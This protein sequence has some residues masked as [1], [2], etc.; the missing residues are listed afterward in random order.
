M[1]G[2]FGD[3]DEGKKTGTIIYFSVAVFLTILAIWSQVVFV[4]SPYYAC[5]LN[6]RKGNVIEVDD[7]EITQSAV[8]YNDEDVVDPLIKDD[9]DKS[10]SL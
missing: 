3:S 9:V 1:L 2:I 5:I 6:K 10:I 8:S 7:N 4:K